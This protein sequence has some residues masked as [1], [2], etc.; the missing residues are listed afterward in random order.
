MSND[1]SP[2]S[3]QPN[4]DDNRATLR[5]SVYGLLIALSVGAMSGRL[6]AINSVDQIGAEKI[7]K[8]Q[9]RKDWQR[10]RP[11]LSGNDRSRWLTARALVEDGTYTIEKY[12]ADPRTHPGW[13][14]ID[15]VMH[16]DSEGVPHL[17][18][19]KPPLLATLYAVPYWVIH[20]L[21]GKTLGTNPYE[22]GRGIIWLVNIV[23]MAIFFYVL[24]L[25]LERYGR[26][27]WGRIFIMAAAAFG[28]FLTTFAVAINNHLPGAVSF[29]VT[30]Y[31]T[32][33]IWYDGDTRLRCFALAGFFAAFTVACELPALSMFALTGAALLWRFPRQT[34]LAF[35]PAALAVVIPYF[36]TNWL[37]HG[38]LRPAYSQRTFEHAPDSAEVISAV[39]ATGQLKPGYYEGT[40]TL[41]NGTVLTLRG[42]EKNWYDYE[43]TRTDREHLVPS[44]W[45]NPSGV[46]AGEKSIATYALHVLIGHHGIFSLTP[47][48]LL[49]IP[50]VVMLG[51]GRDYRLRELALLTIILTVVCIT[52]F[53]FRP[54]ADRNYA[55]TCSGFRWVFWLAPLWLLAALPCA[56]RL[57][58]SK[59]GRCFAAILLALSVL[60]ATYPVWN[61]WTHPWLWNFWVYMGW[62]G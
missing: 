8:S 34:L 41:P 47:V 17:Y 39:D 58:A 16:R 35:A 10:Q 26:T 31:A 56:D 40:V 27:D 24:S 2:A 19:S 11:F 30:L 18:S 14:T 43:F 7:L 57:S 45:R 22:I 49:A 5:R 54:Q 33:R 3:I 51:W 32:L 21:T 4:L 61:P 52:F 53:I 23:P 38:T 42:N 62:T 44:Y 60:S 50:G 15:M 46:D 36:L 55:G 13:D 28:T 59:G 48:W 29:A 20:K 9:E 25:M 12:V 6:L 1:A 37:A